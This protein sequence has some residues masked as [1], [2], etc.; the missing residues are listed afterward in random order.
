M[1]AEGVLPVL[2]FLAMVVAACGGGKPAEPPPRAGTQGAPVGVAS[3][4]A[5]TA[6]ALGIGAPP[7]SSVP[8]PTGKL[9][10]PGPSALAC[11]N[12]T[13]CM[14]HRCNLQ[15]GRCAFPCETD[16][17]CMP[18]NYCYKGPLPACLP[19]PSPP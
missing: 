2:G 16:N 14:T 4:P 12:D 5:P 19:R 13:P 1:R 15:V 11:Q 18:G 7:T 10:T 17:D 6:G 8:P 3:A 9:T